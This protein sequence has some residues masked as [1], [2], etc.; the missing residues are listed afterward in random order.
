MDHRIC[1]VFENKMISYCVYETFY[2]KNV[3]KVEPD[4]LPDFLSDDKS[5][6][7]MLSYLQKIEEDLQQDN[8]L[9]NDHKE[10]IMQL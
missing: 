5:L 2:F 6:E 3:I 10:E 9:V 4:P 7:I 1:S 8:I